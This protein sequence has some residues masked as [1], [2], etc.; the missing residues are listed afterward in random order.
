M[1]NI[2]SHQFVQMIRVLWD[3]MQCHAP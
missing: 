3:I 1:W 2:G